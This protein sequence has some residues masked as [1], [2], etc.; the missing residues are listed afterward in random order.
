MLQQMLGVCSTSLVLPG[1]LVLG[2]TTGMC[3]V[4]TLKT[5]CHSNMP[6]ANIPA[7]LV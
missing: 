6:L 2:I 3:D 5:V 1:W 4:R 7:Y